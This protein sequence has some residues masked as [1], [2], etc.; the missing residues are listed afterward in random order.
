M[1]DIA[2][3]LPCPFC[4]EYPVA[5]DRTIWCPNRDCW[6]PNVENY[7]NMTDAIAAWNRRAVSP[8]PAESGAVAESSRQIIHELAADIRDRLS[9]EEGSANWRNAQRIVEL[10]R[11]AAPSASMGRVTDAQ[12]ID[13]TALKAAIRAILPDGWNSAWGTESHD[14]MRARGYAVT[15]ITS[16]LAALDSPPDHGGG[17]GWVLV[18]REP[19]EAMI[20]AFYGSVIM[21]REGS[22]VGFN[23]G[24]RA[25]LASLPTQ[26][27]KDGR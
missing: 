1:T 24:Y 5:S 26:E 18:P 17:E 25:M 10:S 14:W 16:Y 21:T 19:T 9:K 3:L 4:G 8:A 11:P 20:E 15:A 7:A 13:E 6:G 2:S 23:L 22:A 27:S 12:A